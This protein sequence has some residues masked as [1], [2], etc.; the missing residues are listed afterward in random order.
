V[1]LPGRGAAPL[2]IRARKLI[3][4]DAFAVTG[5]AKIERRAARAD[6]RIRRVGRVKADDVS[7][8]ERGVVEKCAIDLISGDRVSCGHEGVGRWPIRE[9]SVERDQVSDGRC[10]LKFLN[11]TRRRS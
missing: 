3:K 5:D 7:V 11:D 8:A 6:H 2:S 10:H 4:F 9:L 1:K